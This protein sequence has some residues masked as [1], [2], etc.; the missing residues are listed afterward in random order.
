MLRHRHLS[1]RAK[2]SLLTASVVACMMILFGVI[3]YINIGRVLIDNTADSLRASAYSAING[4]FNRPGPRRDG[5]GPLPLPATPAATTTTG[6]G[7][8]PGTQP[9]FDATHSLSDLA[10]FLTNRDTA[11]RTTDTTGATIGDGPAL[12]GTTTVSAPLLD[13]ETYRAVAASGT[14]RHFRYET[15]DGPVLI[16]LV[17]VVHEAGG[18]PQTI[19]VLELSTSLSGVDAFLSR[20]RLLLL[21]GVLLAVIA[22][23]ALLLPIIAGLL[24]P[25]R[26]MAR[27]SRAI[28]AGDLSLRVPVPRGDDE[29]TDLARAFN[30]MVSRLEA[31]FA[32]QRRFIA[33]ASHELRSPLAALGGGVEMLVMGADR[34][35]PEARAR[36]LR[37]MESET[38][39]MSRLVDDLLTLT[40][41]DANP[42][43]TLQRAPVDLHALAADVVEMTRLLAPDRDVRLEAADTAVVVDGD[44][45]R[46]RQALLNLCANARAYTPPGGTITIGVRLVGKNAVLSVADTG[47]GIAPDDLPRIWNRFYRADPARARQSGQGGLGLGLAIVQ[48]IV[49]AHGGSV[50]IE[51]AVGVGTTVTLTLPDAS[52]PARQ[53]AQAD[54]RPSTPIAR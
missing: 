39:R 25:L 21:I 24:R 35:D 43:G 14:E 46:L 2:I 26:R 12:T 45:D 17:P 49:K 42:L 28:A 30:E 23:I 10:S 36:L 50:A 47:E 54:L 34:G 53:Q 6:Q 48:A 41:F 31:A 11:A 8:S 5:G 27:T 52:A 32:T 51:S 16:E 9:P 33:D 13:A 38:A 18:T 7:T 4:P 22:T 20:M 15:A 29:L 37:L 44:T 40:R 1:L 19:G 3:L